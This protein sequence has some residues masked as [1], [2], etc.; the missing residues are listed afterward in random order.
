MYVNP[1][2]RFGC[3]NLPLIKELQITLIFTIA[4]W[5][6]RRY[7]LHGNRSHFQP[8]LTLTKSRYCVNEAVQKDTYNV[9]PE[10]KIGMTYAGNTIK[11]W[12]DEKFNIQSHEKIPMIKRIKVIKNWW[13]KTLT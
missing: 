6:Q 13:M 12:Q 5:R 2:L 3:Y 8:T 7:R 9:Q 1:Q 4:Q 11:N 10:E